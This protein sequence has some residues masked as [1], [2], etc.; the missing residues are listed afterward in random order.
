[1][2]HYRVNKVNKISL[3]D[4]QQHQNFTKQT[5]CIFVTFQY[6]VLYLYYVKVLLYIVYTLKCFPSHLSLYKDCWS[7]SHRHIRKR[8][9]FFQISIPIFHN[10]SMNTVLINLIELNFV[11][12]LLTLKKMIKSSRILPSVAF[13]THP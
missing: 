7:F 5:C 6:N 3:C 10:K 2:M 1:M 4:E 12:S 11:L 13:P 9:F 8:A